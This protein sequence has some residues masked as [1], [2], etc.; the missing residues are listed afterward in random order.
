M[1]LQV[2]NSPFNQEQVE[3]LNQLLPKLTESQQ[4]WLSGY[5][6]AY[7]ATSQ[8]ALKDAPGSA[9]SAEAESVAL[10]EVTILYG[11]QTGNGQEL[12]T[13]MSRDLEEMGLKVTLSSMGDF[14]LN[15]LKKLRHLLL[16]V[17][18][19]GEGDPPDSAL[20]FYEFL[21]G[22]KAPK[23]E[24]L[25]YSVL[26]LGDSSYEFFCETGKRFDAKLEELGAERLCPR[27]DCDLDFDEPAAEWFQSVVSALSEHQGNQQVQAVTTAPPTTDR[28]VYSRTNPFKAEI[29]ENLNL[30]GRG[31]NKETRHLELSLD[32][33]NF[34]FEPGDSLGIYPENQPVLV[35]ELIDEMGWKADELVPVNNRGEERPLREALRNNYEITQLTKPLLQQLA[36]LTS[37]QGLQQLLKPEAEKAQDLSRWTGFVGFSAGLLTLGAAGERASAASTE[38]ARPSILDRQQFKSESG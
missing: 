14:K 17:S 1:Q 13:G 16:V 4:I 20:S 22:R 25:R 36:L 27:T 15:S 37:H 12:A 23:L 28:S 10:Q 11:S 34:Q 35:D 30:N 9:T 19:H 6:S 29:F 18:T 31:S 2:K 38:N 8:A 7:S 26:S 21:H 32:G 24:K 5:L 3:L 33:S